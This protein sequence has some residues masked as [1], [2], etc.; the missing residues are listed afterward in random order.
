MGSPTVDSLKL[1]STSM[2]TG[3]LQR[4][5]FAD[6]KYANE[7]INTKQQ[8][9]A[10]SPLAKISSEMS[11]NIC[12]RNIE[13]STQFQLEE[14]LCFAF[15]SNCVQRHTDTFSNLTAS[16]S[17]NIVPSQVTISS[18]HTAA[19]VLPRLKGKS[20]V[21]TGMYYYLIYPVL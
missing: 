8:I 1:T 13:D 16:K 12:D 17:N 20:S 14:K 19:A 2:V 4:N 9:G 11:D 15:T 3:S 6:S 7:S 10:V 5:T 21:P 18:H